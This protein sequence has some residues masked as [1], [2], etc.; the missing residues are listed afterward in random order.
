M[1][2]YSFR[3]RKLQVLNPII[4]YFT[5]YNKKTIGTDFLMNYIIEKEWMYQL[6]LKK[7][8]N[9]AGK[10]LLDKLSK[11][12]QLIKK[13]LKVSRKISS[14]FLDFC[15]KKFSDKFSDVNN[16]E[17]I[18]LMYNYFD[19]YERFSVA[20]VPPWIFLADQLSYKIFDELGNFLKEDISNIFLTLSTPNILTY[21]RE[22]ELDVLS[23]AIDVKE[24]KNPQ[25][26]D[27]PKFKEIVKKYFWIPFDYLGPEIWDEKYYKKKVKELLSFNIDVLKRQKEEIIQNRKKLETKQ[28]KL[29]KELKLSSEIVGLFE[30]M[31]D[32]AILQDEKKAITTKSHFYLQRLYKEIAKR[33]KMNYSDIYLLLK[34][35]I[36]DALLHQKDVKG[37]AQKRKK[38]FILIL[39]NGRCK[40]IY[41]SEAKKYLRE[42]KILLPSE[43]SGEEINELKGVSA[44]QGK[45]VG[46]VRIIE[47]QKDKP[48][49]KKGEILVATMTTPD[50]VPIMNKAKA[51]ITNE[52]GITCHAAIVSRELGIPCVIGTDIATK[53]L[54]DGDIVEVNADSGIVKIIKRR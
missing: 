29:V 46:E 53:V 2:W 19:F 20:N 16:K 1:E 11:D 41:G 7:D 3:K 25:F 47:E 4:Y 10:F 26:E 38:L 14:D 44:S 27:L 52:G 40:M 32:I 42:N 54:K 34:N 13:S 6:I 22:E 37:I 39:K 43:E 51:I 9:A 28:K 23:L 18:N 48:K 15:R 35:E 30:A 49:F 31:K 45:A 12:K 24:G 21:T 5:A 33:T 8:Y 36:K 50:F 17:L